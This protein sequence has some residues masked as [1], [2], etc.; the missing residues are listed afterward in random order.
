MSDWVFGANAVRSALEA[1]RLK[2]LLHAGDQ[3]R[4]QRLVADSQAASIPC[5]STSH[6][7]LDRLAKGRR[8]QGVAGEVTPYAY[9]SLEEVLA[10]A[11]PVIALDGIEDVGN[12]GAIL[13][14]AYALGAAGVIIPKDG[15]ASVTPQ[16][17]RASAGAASQLPVARVVNLSR[18]LE[19][20]KASGRWVYG[21]AMDGETSLDDLDLSEACVLVL[22]SEGRGMRKK[23]C[24]RCDLLFH[25]PMERSFESLNVSVSAALVLDAWRRSQ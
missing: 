21:A 20:A 6:R 22:G 12:L 1:G 24:S 2:R 14:S 25:I 3:A 19:Q 10:G 18:A 4:I 13:R 15:A 5:E 9:A 7:Q 8:S 23:V 17:E 16:A 11:G